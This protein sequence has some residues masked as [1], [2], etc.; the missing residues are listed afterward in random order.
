MSKP[1]EGSSEKPKRKVWK[2]IVPI[3]IILAILIPLLMYAYAYITVEDSYSKSWSNISISEVDESVL[4]STEFTGEIT[5]HNPTGM[6]IRLVR[7][8]ID[9]WI[10]GNKF[11]TIRETDIDLPA[12][13]SATIPCTWCYD[14][15]IWNSISSPYYEQRI[16]MEIVVSANVL[17]IPITRTFIQTDT[18]T[19]FP[20]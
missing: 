4:E 20:D 6:G 16:R 2:I 19:I 15:Q 1:D 14:S 12:G 9:T 18:E 10:D 8:S 3:I 11:A 5:I 7:V 17:F 13:G